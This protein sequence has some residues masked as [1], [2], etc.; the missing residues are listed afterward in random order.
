M[1]GALNLIFCWCGVYSAVLAGDTGQ[2]PPGA[3]FLDTPMVTRGAAHTSHSDRLL[4]GFFPFLIW[5][6][7]KV[8]DKFIPY[9]IGY[10]LDDFDCG[11][12][13]V[14]WAHLRQAGLS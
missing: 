13:S 12:M 11:L 14:F 4:V 8:L 7:N 5:I 1:L 6:V 3:Q 2:Q 9:K 10:V